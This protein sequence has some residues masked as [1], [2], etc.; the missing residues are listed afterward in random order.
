[1]SDPQLSLHAKVHKVSDRQSLLQA[2]SDADVGD[3]IVLTEEGKYGDIRV[4]NKSGIRIKSQ[5]KQLTIQATFSID[6][7]SSQVII[8][9]LN[10]WNDN[11]NKRQIIIVGLQCKKIIIRHCIISSFPVSMNTAQQKLAGEPRNWI[12]G[13]SVLGNKCDVNNNVLVNVKRGILANGADTIIQQNVIQ[14]FTDDAI[15]VQHHFIKVLHNHVSDAVLSHAG[16]GTAHDAIRLIPPE[17]RYAAGELRGVEV[18]GNVVRSQNQHT[19]VAKHLQARLQGIMGLDGYFT[20]LVISDNSLVLNTNHGIV[21][22]GT[23]NLRLVDNKVISS[24]AHQQITPGIK[25]YLSRLS[26]NP[27]FPK[28]LADKDYSVRYEKNQAPLF[29]IPPEVYESID[30]GH[31]H[32]SKITHEA[33]PDK[34]EQIV[35]DA[36]S[37]RTS[38]APIP[39]A[40]IPPIV[41]TSPAVKPDDTEV[42][43]NVTISPVK[44]S[45]VEPDTIPTVSNRVAVTPARKRAAA[46][47]NQVHR[48]TNAAELRQA[49]KLANAGDTILIAR[50]G[51]YGNVFIINK[52][53]LRIKSFNTDI[54]IQISIVID[55]SSNTILIENMQLWNSDVSRRYII[56]S[57]KSTSN[58]YIR[59]CILSTVRV[60][61]NTMRR[62]YSGN[63]QQ[64]ISGIRMLGKNGQ[65]IS[66]Y[67]MN[68]KMGIMET[69]PNTLVQH[70]LVQFYSE[71]AIRVS[72]HGVKV[73]HNN[74]YDAVAERPGV[75]AHKDAIQLIPPTNVHSAGQLINVKIIGNIIQSHTQP[76]VVAA[77]ERGTV[78]GIFGSDGYFVNTSITGNTVMVNSDHGITL[79][80]VKNLQL[81]DNHIVD[82]APTNNF[83]PGIKLYLTRIFQHGQHKWLANRPHSV[84]L[85]NNQGPTLNIPNEAYTINDQGNNRF[86]SRTHHLARGHNPI[87]VRNRGEGSTPSP[88]IPPASNDHSGTGVSTFTITNKAELERATRVAA[89]GDII[90]FKK[91]GEYGQI[92]LSN[93]TGIRIRSVDSSIAINGNFLI[94]GNSRNITLEGLTLWFSEHNW[95]P[96]ILTGPE[97]ANISI[98]NCL[99]SSS[100]VTRSKARNQMVG[101]PK[102]WVT[103]IWLRGTGNEIINNHLVNV[104]AGIITNGTHVLLQNNLIQYFCDAGIRIINDNIEVI[105]NNIYDAVALEPG[106]RRLLT[107]IQLIPAESRFQGG[108]IRNI[109]ITHNVI[110]AKSSGS[111]TPDDMQGL[112]QGIT[113]HDGYVS[114][115]VLNSNTIVVNTEHGITINGASGLSLNG[116]RVFDSSPGDGIVPGIKLYYTRTVDIDGTRQQVWRTGRDYSVSYSNNQAAAFNIPNV[117]YDANDGGGNQFNVVSHYQARGVNPILAP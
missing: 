10:L 16:E 2:I 76:P 37:A 108:K 69:G 52:S 58:I 107:G 109:K 6:G 3:T 64:W 7:N 14:F 35:Q 90:L 18:I 67:L 17:N 101:R 13:I 96:V 111:P 21:L 88:V 55:G 97:T 25:L 54:P 29:N 92:R 100:E 27:S 8:E 75:E 26:S 47:L 83:N 60:N 91:S 36:D 84:S 113:M 19:S 9:N 39:T 94:D 11:Q 57:G 65:I 70:N 34:T 68:L 103:G 48:V 61:R 99:I 105:H 102:N 38:K 81:Y 71:D 89:P 73:L 23:K 63:P 87:I 1:M 49:I 56:I 112:L 30:L 95:K 79:N 66:N 4:I 43:T 62:H 44:S 86:P 15:R 31:N 106:S 41:S 114:G 42:L 33:T 104:R 28:W 74:I 46:P 53:R 82:L 115:M 24:P 32:F 110:Q 98:R 77:H 85:R 50:A 12:N 116:N 5:S 45:P 40:S 80:G 93:K 51:N 20:D 22:N 78:Q 72:H 117:G 59:N